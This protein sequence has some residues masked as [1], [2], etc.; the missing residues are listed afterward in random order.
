[1][2][3]C[4]GIGRHRRR[5]SEA[6]RGLERAF[7]SRFG[8]VVLEAHSASRCAGGA[9]PLV[10]R[11]HAAGSAECINAMRGDCASGTASVIVAIAMPMDAVLRDQVIAALA[12]GDGHHLYA[13]L[14]A[15]RDGG[16][17]RILDMAG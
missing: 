13:V 16:V 4:P 9:Q 3:S 7:G 10:R 17:A 5:F 1:M 11:S 15:A 12:P 6:E 14:D 8:G 2:R